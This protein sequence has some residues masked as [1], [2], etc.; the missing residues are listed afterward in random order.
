MAHVLEGSH[1]FTCT[2][3]VHSLPEWTI[4]ACSFPAKAGPHSPTPD[5]C[6]SPAEYYCH[7]TSSRL[8]CLV[9]E[10]HVWRVRWPCVW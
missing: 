3:C 8:C 1:S 5:R 2:P 4:H 9:T 6:F 10:V 7:V